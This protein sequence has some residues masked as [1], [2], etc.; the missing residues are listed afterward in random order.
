MMGGGMMGGGV[1]GQAVPEY[2]LFRFIDFNVE[3]GKMYRY[4]V[5]IWFVNPNEGVPD[6]YLSQDLREQKQRGEWKK[7]IASPL[8]DASEAVFVPRDDRLLAVSASS[9]PQVDRE[10]TATIL[11]IHW[12]QQTGTE[13]ADEFPD[14]KRGMVV[15]FPDQDMPQ[16]ETNMGMG[17]FPPGAGLDPAGGLA[18]EGAAGPRERG[19][20]PSP[21]GAGH[22]PAP[23][24]GLPTPGVVAPPPAK[25]DY[26][27]EL[28]VLDIRGGQRLPGRNRD[29]H[30]P[31]EILLLDPDGGLV[32]HRDVDDQ[33]EY[34]KQKTRPAP[35]MMGM[36]GGI[37]GPGGPG[38]VPTPM[39]RGG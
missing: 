36:P 16:P 34:E 6:R 17:G 33:A 29:L 28:L 2:C 23:P 39:P 24:G 30:E 3:P 22:P 32:V 35:G 4:R 27:T 11:A 10:P 15:N 1:P 8:S 20:R 9:S 7:Y 12:D 26:M 21:R 25:I 31:G 18:G 13:V 14:I 37:G 19:R 5:Q 38:P